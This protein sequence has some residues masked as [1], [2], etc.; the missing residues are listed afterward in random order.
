MTP[1]GEQLFQS[2]ETGFG[3]LENGVEIITQ[4][5]EEP[6]G[7]VRINASRQAIEFLLLP[8]LI[9]LRNDYPGIEVEFI[10]N[11][12]F[13]DIVKERYDAGVR[14]GNTVDDGMISVRIG[15]NV[16]M[17]VVASPDFLQRY[18]QPS[19]PSKLVDFPCIGY[20]LSDGSS[21]PWEFN[22]GDRY[23]KHKPQGGWQFN[24][25]S[26]IIQAA[27]LGCGLAYEAED[28]MQEE[29]RTGKLVKIFE[30]YCITFSGF[31]LYFPDRK[32]SNALRIIIEIL[33]VR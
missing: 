32:V 8:K 16:Q 15:P 12:T 33:K 1:A 30:Q 4:L 5:R 23:I 13:V 27:T 17:A 26:T 31:H 29:L 22:D 19:H 24:D 11:N 2:L 6:R 9:T 25:A 14:Y 7:T 21:W 20:R 3:N 10:E 28:L 18:G